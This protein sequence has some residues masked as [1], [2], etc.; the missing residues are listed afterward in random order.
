M[1]DLR[2]ELERALRPR[3]EIRQELGGGGMSRVF[4]AREVELDRDVVIKVLPPETAGL[5][6]A[7]FRRETQMA[8]KLH[9]PHIVP[10]HASGDAAGVLYYTMPFVQGETLRTRITTQK[11]MEADV[12]V[13]ILRD[14]ADAL[15]YAHEQQVVHRDIKPE[16]VLL[17]GGH[18]LVTDF[19]VAKAIAVAEN[20]EPLADNRSL[21]TASGLAIGTPA[22]MAPEQA[23]GDPL[24]DH[25]AD[26]YALG[27]LGYEMLAGRSPFASSTSPHEMIAAHIAERPKPI[28]EVRTDAPLLLAD[29]I[30][31]CLAKRPEDRPASAAAVREQLDAMRTP[32]GGISAATWRSRR[33]PRRV[34]AASV[35]AIAAIALVIGYR[36][37]ESRPTL[38]RNVVAVAPFRVSAPSLG[39][40]R[41][42]MLDL[43]AAV[44]TGEGG[45]RAAS[46][47]T[48]LSAWRRAAG[49][50]TA[51]LPRDAALEVA[52][53]I[54]S[55]Q[56]LL[57]DISGSQDSLVITATLLD[58]HDGRLRANATVS[59]SADSLPQLIDRVT[60]QLLATGAG[61]KSR[62]SATTTASLPALRAYLAGQWLFRNARYKA[63]GDEFKKAIAADSAF[64]V[65][66]IASME[67]AEWTGDMPQ[68]AAAGAIAWKHR[69]K[70][71]TRDRALLTT[72]LGPRY[73]QSSSYSE[74]IAAAQRYR[75]IAPDRPDAWFHFGD[76]LLHHGPF[77]G[78]TA[79]TTQAEVAL[80]KAVELDSSYAPALE[81]LVLIA[82]RRN[83]T[84]ATKRFADLFFA[85]DSASESAIGVRWRV[86]I[87]TGDLK[88]AD[89]IATSRAPLPPTSNSIV[90]WVALED[91]VMVP[92]A[93]DLMK[94]IGTREVGE[95]LKY[96]YM[97]M[98]DAALMVGRPREARAALEQFERE[99]QPVPKELI[100][101]ALTADGDLAAAD[102]AIEA[103]RAEWARA[104]P[105]PGPAL[106]SWVATQCLLPLYQ[107]L[108]HRDTTG[109]RAAVQRLSAL[110]GDTLLVAP[111]AE[112][113]ALLVDGALAVRMAAPD[114]RARV[115]RA[116]S[117]MK[118]G[119]SH[120]LQ[121]IGNPVVARLW[122]AIGDQERALDAIRRRSW[123]LTRKPHF[124]TSLRE[125]G[126]LAAATGDTEGA[127]RAYRHYL[128]LRESA[129]P[130]LRR[131]VNAV[132]DELARIERRSAG[133]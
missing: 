56:L 113:C 89:S 63:A 128:A 8:A 80:A 23:A 133:R 76:A 124:G 68:Y 116:D 29:L 97:M 48:V 126:R 20:R 119:P 44:L 38:D 109:A 10:L 103:I 40:L 34:A 6:V 95:G 91:G 17:S 120:P 42:G 114:A 12:V 111:F 115:A 13:R 19:G 41:E 108:S 90:T 88:T 72:Q 87:A 65:A 107:M 79:A 98:H 7:R 55:G 49:T 30:M 84:V 78:N 121:E 73:P 5:N 18:A 62:L 123:F 117:A 96:G 16:N 54:G 60:T 71:S 1:P 51:N 59:G 36:R 106:G 14:I 67:A 45:P 83:D 112:T 94:R 69:D 43:F 22:Y 75:D 70:L 125:E 130:E 105:A 131:E 93:Y 37:A 31:R 74:T 77:V 50:D 27:L 127:I 26:L 25:R 35:V 33:A 11:R 85:A 132:R 52:E 81:H 100:K 101:E 92:Q 15:A 104:R 118:S 82:A 129:E 4:R 32:S 110:A 47:R 57:G 3:Y 24:T 122:E 102:S 39:Y 99:V 2:D 46:P 66:A 58:V 21:A 64:A 86:A 9:H 28:Q 61:E 53:E